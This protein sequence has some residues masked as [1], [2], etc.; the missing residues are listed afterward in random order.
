MAGDF[1]C[2]KGISFGEWLHEQLHGAMHFE[3]EP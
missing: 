2:E 3:T 1:E